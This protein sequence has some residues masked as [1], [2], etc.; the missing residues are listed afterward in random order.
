[1]LFT[2]IKD[3]SY[4]DSLEIFLDYLTYICASVLLTM[5]YLFPLNKKFK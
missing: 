1:M 5:S 2:F 3:F 4:V